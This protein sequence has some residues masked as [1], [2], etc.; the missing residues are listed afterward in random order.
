MSNLEDLLTKTIR[1]IANIA[2]EESYTSK[3]LETIKDKTVVFVSKLV[4]AIDRRSL[5][6]NEEFILNAISCIT[7]LLFYDVP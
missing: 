6:S 2:I 7:N 4:D 5:E 1:L 3:S